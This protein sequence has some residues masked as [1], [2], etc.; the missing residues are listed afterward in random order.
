LLIAANAAPP[1]GLT[2]QKQGCHDH[3]RRKRHR[4]CNHAHEGVIPI[5]LD[6][7][8]ESGENTVT[9]LRG[10]GATSHSISVGLTSPANCLKAVEFPTKVFNRPFA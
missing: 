4:R 9:E 8:V 5:I 2:A 1:D 6:R 3:G 7:D 10:L